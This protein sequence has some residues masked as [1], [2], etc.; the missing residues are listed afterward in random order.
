MITAEI[1]N[2]IGL[3]IFTHT[4][5]CETSQQAAILGSLALR[6]RP[7]L[8][9]TVAIFEFFQMVSGRD[10]DRAANVFNLSRKKLRKTFR[11]DHAHEWDVLKVVFEAAGEVIG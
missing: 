2:D 6:L 4:G 7:D 5:M 1:V 8:P 10:L 3:A 9:E 11:D